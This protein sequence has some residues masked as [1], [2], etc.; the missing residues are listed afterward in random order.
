VVHLVRRRPGPARP[1]LAS[2]RTEIR[3]PSGAR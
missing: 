1:G 2:S 3:A